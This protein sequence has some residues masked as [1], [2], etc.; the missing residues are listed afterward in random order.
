MVKYLEE[1]FRMVTHYI[2]QTTCIAGGYMFLGKFVFD[3]KEELMS[4]LSGLPR[5]KSGTCGVVEK[6]LEWLSGNRW[7]SQ[8]DVNVFLN[9]YKDLRSGMLD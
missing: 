6:C 2:L 9:Q 8:E 5:H 7:E 3:W 4:Q 1:D